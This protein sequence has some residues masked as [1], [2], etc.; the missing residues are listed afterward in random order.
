MKGKKALCVGIVPLGTVVR[1]RTVGGHWRQRR[2][3]QPGQPVAAQQTGREVHKQRRSRQLEGVEETQSCTA[4]PVH[5]SA[6]VPAAWSLQQGSLSWALQLGPPQW[7][8][9]A[10]DEGTPTICCDTVDR[11]LHCTWLRTMASLLAHST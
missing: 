2:G 8:D 4:Q 1:G 7:R 3:L 6:N 5:A 11:V 10:G 9:T